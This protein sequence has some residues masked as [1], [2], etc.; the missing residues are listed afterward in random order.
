MDLKQKLQSNFLHFV[1][2]RHSLNTRNIQ[3]FLL[4]YSSLDNKKSTRQKILFFRSNFSGKVNLLKD[5]GKSFNSEIQALH[6][7]FNQ[8][9]QCVQTFSRGRPS[10]Y[11]EKI[12]LNS[13][14][15]YIENIFLHI[16]NVEHIY[17]LLYYA[18]SSLSFLLSQ[19]QIKELKILQL[20]PV[21]N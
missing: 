12:S 2:K 18:S 16:M 10:S 15:N 21:V 5:D 6:V 20:L 1:I 3:K 8:F 7:D 17:Y 19:F 4:K 13:D 14:E 11:S 9:Y